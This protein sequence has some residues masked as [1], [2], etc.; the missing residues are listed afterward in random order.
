MTSISE[1]LEFKEE[2][3]EEILK[4]FMDCTP[5]LNESDYY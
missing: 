1:S 4:K 5:L 3:G 2:F